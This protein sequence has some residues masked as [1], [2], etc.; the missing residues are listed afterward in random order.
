V[1]RRAIN[2][3]VRKKEL[4]QVDEMKKVKEELK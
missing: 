3:P 2:A 4:I 1:E